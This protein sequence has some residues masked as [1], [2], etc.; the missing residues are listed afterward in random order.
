MLLWCT[1][2]LAGCTQGNP[3]HDANVSDASGLAVYAGDFWEPT[4]LFAAE[5]RVIDGGLWAVHSPERRNLMVPAG[6]HRFE[7]VGL[8]AEVFV[9]FDVVGKRVKAVRRYIN[10]E[11]RGEFMPFERR[12]ATAL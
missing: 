9:E 11:L 8:D 6:A 10:G 7:M 2:V 1:V 5:T 12:R 4:E 3:P